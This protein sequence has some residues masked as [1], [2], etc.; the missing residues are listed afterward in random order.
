MPRPAADAGARVLERFVLET[1]RREPNF[2]TVVEELLSVGRHQMRHWLPPVYMPVQPQ[3]A[4]HRVR[5]SF[6]SF[7]EFAIPARH[8]R[9]SRIPGI[10]LS[11]VAG[12]DRL[13][14]GRRGRRSRADED[15][16]QRG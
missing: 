10:E 6:F 2:T 5:H 12:D 1:L 16:A 13:H 7:V 8:C 11:L 14:S 15:G 3:A 4:I 9:A